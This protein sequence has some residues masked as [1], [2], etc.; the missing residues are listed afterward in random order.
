MAS[1]TCLIIISLTACSRGGGDDLFERGEVL[2]GAGEH[3]AAL[4]LYQALANK[5][6]ENAHAPSARYRIGM[7]HYLH[8][9][10]KKKALDAYLSLILLYPESEE[11][12]TARRDMAEIY[13]RSGEHRKAIGEYQWLVDHS[14]GEERD[15][16]RYNIAM[17][18]QNL[19]DFKQA[20]V[21]IED[22]LKNAPSEILLP[23]LYYQMG[24]NQYLNG[25]MEGAMTTYDTVIEEYPYDP[26]SIEAMLGKAVI[27]EEEGRLR[28]A[29]A[30]LNSLV[31][32]YPNREAIE[33]RVKWVNRRIRERALRRQ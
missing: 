5:F 15:V 14:S 12:A 9:G 22:I 18:Y 7:I 29:A 8:T 32:S 2:L 17:E 26:L 6:P 13:R 28:D 27:L 25:D 16:H 11:I 21:E 3:M 19:S 33:V 10:N 30:L 24:N 31:K 20:I 4:E 1:V 23:K